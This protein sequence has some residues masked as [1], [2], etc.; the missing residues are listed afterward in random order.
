[1]PL[2]RLGKWAGRNLVELGKKS[3][4]LQLGRMPAANPMPQCE[5]ELWH[6]R[7][8]RHKRTQG[9]QANHQSVA[10][11]GC[12][13][14]WCPGLHYAKDC[15][16]ARKGDPFPLSSTGEA[17]PGAL[18]PVLGFSVQ[19]KDTWHT[20]GSREGSQRC[21]RDWS[22]SHVRKADKSWHYWP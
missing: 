11:T 1:M 21:W 20:G 5:L 14:G 2:C 19:E 13:G 7:A 22:T 16:Q 3:R 15:Q 17:T 8:A 10:C 18:Y 4:V 9:R 12:Q 6:W